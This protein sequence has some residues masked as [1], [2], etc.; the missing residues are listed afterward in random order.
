M[1][2]GGSRALTDDVGR[3]VPSLGKPGSAGLSVSSLAA[4]PSL[5]RTP[6]A[7]QQAAC[8]PGNGNRRGE[9]AAPTGWPDPLDGKVGRA[10]A[11]WGAGGSLAG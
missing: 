7:P 4:Y 10:A 3:S 8:G 1:R 5:V 11:S 6:F 2:E 9:R